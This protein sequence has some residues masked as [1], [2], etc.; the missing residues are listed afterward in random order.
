MKLR[1]QRQTIGMIL[2][3]TQSPHS[4]QIIHKLAFKY[5]NTLYPVNRVKIK[6]KFKRSVE[7]DNRIYSVSTEK[8]L[9][10]PI[11]IMGV[12]NTFA[13]SEGDAKNIIFEYF[14]IKKI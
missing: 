1:P 10:V 9:F 7:I 12:S 2:V 3:T 5:L 6:G 8:S 14:K 11:L 13:V 4:D